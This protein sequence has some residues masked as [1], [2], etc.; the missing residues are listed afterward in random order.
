MIILFSLDESDV[1]N[2]DIYGLIV[3]YAT[4]NLLVFPSHENIFLLTL[5][6]QVGGG[7]A[8]R[9]SIIASMTR[10]PPRILETRFRIRSVSLPLKQVSLSMRI[11]PGP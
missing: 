2:G 4:A 9:S 5:C 8:S 1:L 10:F 3:P 6:I 11:Q 7:R